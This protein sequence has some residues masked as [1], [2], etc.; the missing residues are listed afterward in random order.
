MEQIEQ[1]EY[2]LCIEC[3]VP[4]CNS[5]GTIYYVLVCGKKSKY[6]AEQAGE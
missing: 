5:K 3:E 1:N 4:D 6:D 2:S